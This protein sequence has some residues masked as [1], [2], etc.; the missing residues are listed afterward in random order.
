MYTIMNQYGKNSIIIADADGLYEDKVY[1]LLGHEAGRLYYWCDSTGKINIPGRS[2]CD[3][4]RSWELPPSVASLYNM[5]QTKGKGM[6]VHTVTL[7]GETGMLYTMLLNSDWVNSS[8]NISMDEAFDEIVRAA[9]CVS[10]DGSLSDGCAILVLKD[11]DPNGYELGVFFPDKSCKELCNFYPQLWANRFRT[12]VV[13][14]VRKRRLLVS[15]PAGTLLARASIDPDY[16]GIDIVLIDEKGVETNLA[17]VE[18]TPGGEC[19]DGDNLI[20]GDIIPDER[21]EFNTVK[22]WSGQQ[23]DFKVL[24]DGLVARVWNDGNRD[25]PVSIAYT[26]LDN[27]KENAE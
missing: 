17:L 20:L 15:T 6:R 16:P 24:T 3:E 22:L 13:Q 23:R 26:N 1:T 21:T 2:P 7:N 4:S 5:Y 10:T 12:I 14:N 8:L 18:Y 11:T 9:I 19:C 25:D 27:H